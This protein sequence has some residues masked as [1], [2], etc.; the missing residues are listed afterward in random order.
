VHLAGDCRV[1]TCAEKHRRSSALTIPLRW[2]IGRLQKSHPPWCLSCCPD[3]RAPCRRTLLCGVCDLLLHLALHTLRALA[4]LLLCLLLLHLLLQL[5]AILLLTK[6]H[7]L[8]HAGR[9]A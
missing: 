6:A 1:R 5:C 4:R 7:G 9:I 3:Q 2:N 8:R